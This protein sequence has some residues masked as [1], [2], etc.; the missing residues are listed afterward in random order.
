MA[1]HL[2]PLPALGGI[3]SRSRPGSLPQASKFLAGRAWPLGVRVGK[4]RGGRRQTEPAVAHVVTREPLG[5]SGEEWNSAM[6][7]VAWEAIRRA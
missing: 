1:P 5:T 2:K 6:C 3:A 4:T 7:V